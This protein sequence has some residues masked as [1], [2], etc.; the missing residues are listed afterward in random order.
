MKVEYNLNRSHSYIDRLRGARM[1]EDGIYPVGEGTIVDSCKDSYVLTKSSMLGSIS[2]PKDSIIG[3]TDVRRYCTGVGHRARN[4]TPEG[5]EFALWISAEMAK[6]NIYMI[7][8]DADG[9]DA[10]MVAN[11]GDKCRVFLPYEGF[12]N[13]LGRNDSTRI[14]LTEDQKRY[15]DVVLTTGN[16]LP[17]IA[18]MRDTDK[19]Y[20]RR[21]F[22]Q[23]WNY[24]DLPEA[25]FYYAKEDSEGVI[26][27]GTRTAVYTA[28]YF[29]I[30]CYNFYTQEGRDAIYEMFKTDGWLK[31]QM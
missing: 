15:A 4:M 16:I 18:T 27:G 1:S 25:C 31:D 13:F 20:H 30:P 9:I 6:R 14:L 22:F 12:G 8:G 23:S 2:I 24:G 3:V 26:E 11:S 17:E 10:A 5:Q 21:N 28:R 7:S 29:G 19:D